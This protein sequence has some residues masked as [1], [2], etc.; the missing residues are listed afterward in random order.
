M[1]ETTQVPSSSFSARPRSPKGDAPSK[2][3]AR[4]HREPE[5]VRLVGRQG[6]V[7]L[8]DVTGIL[9][10]CVVALGLFI[11]PLAMTLA[12]GPAIVFGLFR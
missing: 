3:P 11:L 5:L 6:G 12:Q 1:S 8:P 9:V 2:A 4:S 7:E 10:L